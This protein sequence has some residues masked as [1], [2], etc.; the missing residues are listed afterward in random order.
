MASV[1]EVGAKLSSRPHLQWVSISKQG[2]LGHSGP[3][4]PR[5][6]VSGEL[7]AR[8]VGSADVTRWLNALL[9]RVL[10]KPPQNGLTSHGLKSTALSWMA[11]SGYSE[12]TR[13]ILG[14]HSMKGRR[15]LET[16]S[17]GIMAPYHIQSGSFLP[18]RTRSGY[19]CQSSAGLGTEPTGD[20]YVLPGDEACAAGS[21][22]PEADIDLVC[23]HL[24]KTVRDEHKITSTDD[25]AAAP[26]ESEGG[27]ARLFADV[28]SSQRAVV[29]NK[30]QSVEYHTCQSD[31]STSS[32]SSS[33][34]SESDGALEGEAPATG[35]L[36]PVEEWRPGCDVYQN[37]KTKTLHLRAIGSTSNNFRV[38]DHL[39]RIRK[40]LPDESFTLVSGNA[41]NVSRPV[42]FVMQ[43]R[44]LRF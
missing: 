38:G 1:L 3:L 39:E 44:Q 19:V 43:A 5:V 31:S 17:R 6:G 36:K 26:C 32:S 37:P 11:K 12:S 2:T 34:G 10:E 29:E 40:D 41:S 7:V 21:P 28:R 22:Q 24:G 35:A 30:E 8:A 18:D 9:E 42:P 23:E 4:L 13:L 15:T 27:K 33:S 25:A 16:Y 20:P 14:H